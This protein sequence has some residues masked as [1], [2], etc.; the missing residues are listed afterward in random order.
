MEKTLNVRIFLISATFKSA[1]ANKKVE[2]MP[3]SN[4]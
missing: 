4:D 3:C 2:R 1:D